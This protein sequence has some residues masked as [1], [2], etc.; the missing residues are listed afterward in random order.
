MTR[1]KQIVERFRQAALQPPSESIAALESAGQRPVGFL[2]SY[3][4]VE[5]LSVEGLAPY[6]MRGVGWAGTDFADTYLGRVT[7]SYVRHVLETEEEGEFGALDGMVFIACCDHMRRLHDNLRYLRELPFVSMLDLPHKSN[8]AAV[9]WYAEELERLAG[10]LSSS[11]G[12]DCG[13]EAVSRAIAS[14]NRIRRHIGDIEE[15]RNE[16]GCPLTGSDLLSVTN[17]LGN[18]PDSEAEGGLEELVQLLGQGGTA[19]SAARGRLILVA[20]QLDDPGYLG[21]I[22]KVGGLIV[23]E[24]VCTG[25]SA[26]VQPVDEDAPPFEALA[27]RYL[28]RTP[29]PRMMDDSPLLVERVRALVEE[30]RADGVV[31]VVMK[32]CD[33]WGIEGTMIARSLREEGIPVLRLEREYLLSGEGQLATRVQAFLESFR[34]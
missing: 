1:L 19:P 28:K 6:R 18:L 11:L 2:C 22:E 21:V 29:C 12:V 3:T 16:E 30:R 34:R 5:L 15:A 8:P 25:P 33:T 14:R 13:G 26:M 31:V 9:R 32:F 23:G 27:E 20:S 4:P 10:E 7:C 24:L 17:G